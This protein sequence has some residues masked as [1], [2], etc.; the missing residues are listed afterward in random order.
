[1]QTFVF[2]AML[3]LI[4]VFIVTLAMPTSAETGID[5]SMDSLL[6]AMII[7]ES[8]GDVNAIGKNGELGCLQIRTVA[9]LDVNRILRR[10]GSTRQ[11]TFSDR[12]LEE[13]SREIAKVYL[14]HYAL[15]AVDE[16]QGAISYNEI[17]ARVWNGG[18]QGYKKKSTIPYWRK[19]SKVL[20]GE[21]PE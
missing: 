4:A 15:L 11:Y 12:L 18:P 16:M 20:D 21:M 9:V 2:A 13:K 7:V 19:V 1:M 3:I 10:Q 14:V 8:G 17:M 6:S 5:D